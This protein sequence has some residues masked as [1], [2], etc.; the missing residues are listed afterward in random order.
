MPDSSGF[1]TE[2]TPEP[3]AL[4][5]KTAPGSRTARFSSTGRALRS[6]YERSTRSTIGDSPFGEA[7]RPAFHWKKRA[8]GG[9][10]PPSG[11]TGIQADQVPSGLSEFPV[12]TQRARAAPAGTFPSHPRR[13]NV[14]RRRP[15]LTA[16][17]NVPAAGLP[18]APG[19]R[20]PADPIVTTAKPGPAAGI[21]SAS[22]S[23]VEATR[24]TWRSFHSY[25]R[26]RGPVATRSAPPASRRKLKTDSSGKTQ[27]GSTKPSG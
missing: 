23:P 8:T 25:T 1:A 2:R 20:I 22:F 3:P 12:R 17:V 24:R 18:G 27:A 15:S 9:F 5:E 26:P 10:A 19:R 14:D 11:A 4:R 21:A 16:E 6:A 7:V 13:P